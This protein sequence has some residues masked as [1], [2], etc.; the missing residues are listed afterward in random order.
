[1]SLDLEVFAWFETLEKETLQLKSV[2][3]SWIEAAGEHCR[4]F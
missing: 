2:L 3:K 1:M 4:R